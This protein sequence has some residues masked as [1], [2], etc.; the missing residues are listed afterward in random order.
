MR[1]S[2]DF[3][4][5]DSPT[6][7]TTSP[8]A[9]ARLTLSTACTTLGAWPAPSRS[10]RR[11]ARSACLTKRLLEPARLDDRRQR[12]R[13]AGSSAVSGRQQRT[14]RRGDRHRDRRRGVA[15]GRGARAAHAEQAARRRVEQRRRHAGDLGRA[16]RRDGWRTA[17]SR[18]GPWC[19]DAAA[20]G[21]GRSARP[22]STMR[23]GVH[24]GDAVGQRRHHREVVRDPDHGRA[25]RCGTAPAPRAGSAPGSSRRAP[26]SARRRS[27]GRAR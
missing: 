20:R 23:A 21:S 19:R 12:S 2:V 6:R 26:W 1:P 10:S 13:H 15:L 18:A 25:V 14:S 22:C 7:P 16:A 17:P 9:I 27:P 4:Q 11:S 8:L 5:P 3:P 24:H